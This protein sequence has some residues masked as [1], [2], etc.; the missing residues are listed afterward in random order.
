M[1]RARFDNLTWTETSGSTS[2]GTYREIPKSYCRLTPAAIE[3]ATA[4]SRQANMYG[5][6]SGS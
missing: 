6:V 4:A 3:P 1:Y 2:S 5:N